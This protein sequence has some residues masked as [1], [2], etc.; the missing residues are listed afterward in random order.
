MVPFI[1]YDGLRNLFQT[2]GGITFFVFWGVYTGSGLNIYVMMGFAL[3]NIMV[4]LTS[5]YFWIN[6]ISY[7]QLL[8]LIN[9]TTN[10]HKVVNSPTHSVK[11]FVVDPDLDA[12]S[13]YDNLSQ[14]TAIDDTASIKSAAPST[15]PAKSE[16]LG[17][18]L[19]V[20][21]AAEV[22]E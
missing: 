17:S 16:H 12:E 14:H 10:I 2:F 15:I 5:W 20:K 9:K 13:P 6:I 11:P 3:A 19:S 21:K 8:R 1:I 4:M 18:K 7:C 22:N